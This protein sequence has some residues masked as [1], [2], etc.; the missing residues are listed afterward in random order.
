MIEFS[1]YATHTGWNYAALYC[2]FYWGIA[3][4]IKDQLLSLDHPPNVPTTQGL[5]NTWYWEHQGE[6]AAPSGWNRQ[7]ASTSAPAKLGNNPTASCDAPMTGHT[8]PGISADGKLTQE[9][10]K[11]H[12]LKGL[13]YYCGLTIDFPAPNCQN[14]QHPKSPVAGHSTFTIMGEPKVSIEEVVEVPLTELEN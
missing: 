13:C 9:E 4:P 12:C 10:W 5:C 2:E 14:T 1:D 7:S 6:K 8:N 3:E 11:C